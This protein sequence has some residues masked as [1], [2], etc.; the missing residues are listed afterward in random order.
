MTS[1]RNVLRLCVAITAFI[2]GTRLVQLTKLSLLVAMF[3]LSEITSLFDLSSYLDRSLVSV[4]V[5]VKKW[6]AQWASDK[7]E[8]KLYHG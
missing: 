2:F 5:W 7:E 3:S 6:S 8:Q 1:L 4:K